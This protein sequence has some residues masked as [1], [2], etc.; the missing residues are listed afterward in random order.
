MIFRKKPEEGSASL[1]GIAGIASLAIA[2][3]FVQQSGTRTKQTVDQSKE[4]RAREASNIGV[5]NSLARFKSLIST[6]LQKDKSYTPSVFAVNYYDNDWQL[7]QKKGTDANGSFSFSAKSRGDVRA[8]KQDISEADLKK[9]MNGGSMPVSDN[10]N[11]TIEIIKPNFEASTG[12]LVESVDV[13]VTGK[14]IVNGL[15]KNTTL[16]ARVGLDPPKPFDAKI[17]YRK[18]GTTDELKKV[19]E[20]ADMSG[21]EYDFYIVAS[22]IAFTGELYVDGKVAHK[23]DN[24]DKNGRIPHKAVNYDARDE[25]INPEPIK[26]KM[27]AEKSD[28]SKDG[29][30]A[31]VVDDGDSFNEAT[32]TYV[33][34]GGGG[35]NPLDSPSGATGTKTLKAIVYGPDEKASAETK[36]IK[37]KTEAPSTG[38]TNDGKTKLSEGDYANLCAAKNQCTWVPGDP[39]DGSELGRVA[40]YERPTGDISSLYTYKQGHDP[41]KWQIFNK[42][43]CF[44]FSKVDNST[45]NLDFSKATIVV[46]DTK[47]CTKKNLFQRTKCGCVTADTMI[48]LGDGVTQKRIDEIYDQDLVW[49]PLTKKAMP[50]RKITAGPEKFPMIK[51]I[52]DGKE[53]R[54][55][56]KHP[57]NTRDGIVPA[58]KLKAGEEI[59]IDAENFRAISSV[60]SLPVLS[61]AKAPV[62]WNIEIEAPDDDHE[63]H[64]LQANGI[65]TGD[66]M[67]QTKLESG[68]IH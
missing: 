58:F 31:K 11:F 6:R 56:G 30:G 55:T 62:V 2:T 44:N 57:F 36:E 7:M 63:A 66:L 9:L 47:T 42:K 14:S 40:S 10:D 43:V 1:V 53:I 35:S 41:G 4:L 32:C 25:K 21:G 34:S 54:A 38:K 12:A 8:G 45:H 61:D 37:V 50:I 46:Y 60:E 67:I 26:I 52:V 51:I 39:G 27:M 59:Q 22:G 17:M 33:P 15:A 24:F 3:L 49:N 29:G 20:G 16:S 64:Y 18:S 48:T 65:S 28:P 19:V 13:T 23:T 68:L 5:E